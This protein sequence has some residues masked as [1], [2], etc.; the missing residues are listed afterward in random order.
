MIE[1]QYY[2]LLTVVGQP[3][4]ILAF[5]TNI[6]FKKRQFTKSKVVVTQSERFIVVEMYTM[7]AAIRRRSVDSC[8]C[9]FLKYL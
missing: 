7:K 3:V 6:F 4:E 2:R 8:W 9:L 1:K 5:F